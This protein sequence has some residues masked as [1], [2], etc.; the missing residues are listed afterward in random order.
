MAKD[1]KA[2]A[3]TILEEVGGPE[4]VKH[5]MHC[6]TRLRFTLN[7][8]DVATA[9]TDDIKAID[10]VIDVIVQNGQYQV[11]IGPDVGSVYEY[12]EK[13]CGAGEVSDGAEAGADAEPEKPQ[14]LMDKIFGTISGIFTPVVPVLMASGMM[15][16][17][18]TIL[19]L[20][21]LLTSDTTTYYVLNIIYDAGFYFL[22]IFI[23]YTASQKLGVTP[24]L[25]MLLAA[26]MLHP[27]LTEFTDLGVD[28][29]SIF[30]IAIPTVD[31]SKTVLPIILG[32]WLMGYIERFMN[33]HIPAIIRGFAAPVLTMLI[34]TPIMLVVIGPLGDTIGDWLGVGVTWL[35]DNLGPLA[36][37]LLGFFTPVM[38]ATG[39]HSFAFAVIVA[40]MTSV[41]YDQLLMPS[42]LA[43]N[44]AM[45]G[46]AL[47]VGVLSHDVETR[48]NAISASLSAALGISEPAMY[49]ITLPSGY[50]FLGAMIGGCIGGAVAGIG[51]LR[52][53]SLA[54][55][56]VIGIPA[57]FG[58]AGITNVIVGIVAIVV[59]FVAAFVATYLLGKKNV[60][61]SLKKKEA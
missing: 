25:G 57:M 50:G 40:S 38:I 7:D 56:S 16:A 51:G 10:G 47:A 54:S 1:Y 27:D 29:L 6:A 26:I 36:V 37:A 49:G 39:T 24:V 8:I 30:G 14:K 3:D 31:Y 21:G 18:L 45:A 41:G 32:I 60:Q 55:S 43:E 9:R 12:V 52:F 44:L 59:S 28:Q 2:M 48:S 4:N 33:K 34:M 13:E 5:V 23:A 20:T 46:A 61:F 15:G 35:G 19:D 42:M 17:I 58:E 11:C 22:P 53:Y